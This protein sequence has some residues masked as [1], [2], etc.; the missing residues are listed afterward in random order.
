MIPP[1][2]KSDQDQTKE[3]NNRKAEILAIKFFPQSGQAD[4]NNINHHKEILRFYINTDITE[5]EIISVL[6]KLPNRKGPGPDRILNKALKELEKKITPGIAKAI[7]QIFRNREIPT[8]LKESTIIVLYKDKKK[9]Y[10]L[11]S[12]Y[13][14]I[15]LENTIVKVI[16][17]I[18]ANRIISKAKSR[19]LI[20]QNQIGARKKRLT[21]LAL[22]L[23][24]GLI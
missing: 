8:R 6:G 18:I 2:C 17:K 24:L 15:I 9:D 10:S 19:G 21:L 14:L 5:G 22:E 16:K 12:S 1:L 23:L 7:S 3:A 4:L 13:R 11:L 20:L